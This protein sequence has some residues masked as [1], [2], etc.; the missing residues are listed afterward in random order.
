MKK[1][2]TAATIAGAAMFAMTGQASADG[3]ACGSI[4]IAEMDWASAEFIAN[5]DKIILEE[6]FGCEVE[7]TPGATMTTF[8]SMDSKGV[9]DVAPELWANAVQTPL[10]KAVSEDRMAIMNSAPIS[11]AG[12]GWMIDSK[13]ANANN[14]K[15]LADVIARPDLFPHPEDPSKGG[16]VTCPSGWGCQI[17]SNQLFKAF[18]MEA[19]GWMIVDSGSSAGLNGTIE[20]ALTRNDSWFGYYWGPTVLASRAGLSLLDMGPFAGDDNWD[21]CVMDPECANPKPSGWV[22]SVVTTV[23]ASSFME[24]GSKVSQTYLA[25]RQFPAAVMDAMLKI[26]YNDQMEGAVIAAYFLE[27]HPEVWSNWVPADVAS[28]IKASL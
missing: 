2:L 1:L 4:V 16:F 17:A 14:L 22:K 8:A 13:T 24:K 26:K 21:N 25:K 6:G 3:H 10:K 27:N 12:E 23:V 5:V 9:P 20:K 28:K 11:G 7:L 19:K 18:D 15:S